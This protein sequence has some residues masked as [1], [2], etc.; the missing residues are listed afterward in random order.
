MPS[1]KFPSPTYGLEFYCMILYQAYWVV[2]SI[3]R[4]CHS[5]NSFK[6]LSPHVK[7][8]F[9]SSSCLLAVPTR[10]CLLSSEYPYHTAPYPLAN[11]PIIAASSSTLRLL[12]GHCS[13]TS[14]SLSE[15]SVSA[16]PLPFST[17]AFSASHFS[18][19]LSKNSFISSQF[20][21][22]RTS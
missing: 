2:L 20:S 19:S 12:A 9:R 16:P 10:L 7:R 3:N 15:L 5:V 22:L 21:S 13:F 8:L 14:A 18:S 11:P 1:I 4:K 17:T 6:F